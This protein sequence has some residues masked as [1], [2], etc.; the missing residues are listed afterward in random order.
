MLINLSTKRVGAVLSQKEG[1]FEQVMAYVNKTLSL[2][3]KKFHP[4]EGECYA[5]IWQIMHY[6]QYLH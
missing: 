3:H 4:M 1:M 2:V 6:K 5:L